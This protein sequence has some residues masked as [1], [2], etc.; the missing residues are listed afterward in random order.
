[1]RV[2]PS[3]T[4]GR[5]LLVVLQFTC[6]IAL[7]VSTVIIYQQIQH[8]KDRPRGLRSEPASQWRECRKLRCA[9]ARQGD[10]NRRYVAA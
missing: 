2:G 6:S 5:K 8:A 1:M 4:L 7:I 3:A 9:E 10:A